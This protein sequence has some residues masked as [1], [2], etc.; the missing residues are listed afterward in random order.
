MKKLLYILFFL[1]TTAAVEPQNISG[2]TPVGVNSTQQYEFDNGVVYTN[3][4]WVITGGTV[5]ASSQNGPTYDVWVKWTTAGTGSVKFKQ[6][7]NGSNVVGS[8]TVTVQSCT[9]G[10]PTASN[11]SICG[12]GTMTATP[13]TN[14]TTVRWYSAS[15]GGIPLTTSTT[16]PSTSTTTTYYIASYNGT[17]RCESTP[18]VAVTL[19][20]TPAPSAPTASNTSV[21]GSGTMNATPGANADNIKWY[22]ASTGGSS[23]ATSLTSPSTSTTTTYYITSYNSTTLCESTPRTAVTLTVNPLPAAP[24]ASATYVCTSGTRS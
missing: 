24:T 3:Y 22:S 14:A 7:D 21:C 12:T 5:V 20:I 19:T 15:T 1:I 9:I 6:M 13:G 2:L 11:T 4:T 23:L 10:A 16:S 18:R 8:L 17:T